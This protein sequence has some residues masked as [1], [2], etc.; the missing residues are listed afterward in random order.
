MPSG[1]LDLTRPVS[2]LVFNDN[3]KDTTL[4]EGTAKFPPGSETVVTL[5]KVT[6]P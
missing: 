4:Q 6:Q 2:A 3:L 1:T 5:L